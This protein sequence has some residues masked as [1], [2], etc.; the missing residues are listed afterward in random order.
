[1]PRPF[2]VAFPVLVSD[3]TNQRALA[4][5]TTVN[6]SVEAESAHEAARFVGLRLQP[7]ITQAMRLVNRLERLRI[8]MTVVLYYWQPNGSGAERM[9]ARTYGT[10]EGVDRDHNSFR[11]A[12]GLGEGTQSFEIPLLD[13]AAVQDE[14]QEPVPGPYGVGMQVEA[15]ADVHVEGYFEPRIRE[16]FPGPLRYI[17]ADQRPPEAP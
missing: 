13:L 3:E 14:R 9:Q 4:I 15:V 10:F 7:A 6:I 2:R 17:P 11:W 8:G 1:M 12:W 5:Q 16:N